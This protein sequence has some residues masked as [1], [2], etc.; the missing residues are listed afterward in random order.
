M[1]PFVELD[2]HFLLIHVLAKLV[3][4]LSTHCF[5]VFVLSAV[6]VAVWVSSRPKW[7]H[8][9]FIMCSCQCHQASQCQIYDELLLA[10]WSS[11]MF[12]NWWNY[13][14]INCGHCPKNQCYPIH[15]W[16]RPALALRRRVLHKYFGFVY[17]IRIANTFVVH[18]P[19]RIKIE[20]PKITFDFTTL[21][22]TA[23]FVLV[24]IFTFLFTLPY[25]F[26]WIFSFYF[27]VSHLWTYAFTWPLCCFAQK[28]FISAY[29]LL[30]FWLILV[31]YLAISLN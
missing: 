14:Y 28:K 27:T 7:R 31:Y 9:V 5:S 19:K 12:R 11:M 17:F 2:R 23:S 20:I 24:H 10:I 15:F 6:C 1:I 26:T 13:F 30:D 18:Y 16:N 8:N 21:I 29:F 22:F 25:A 3:F 4:A